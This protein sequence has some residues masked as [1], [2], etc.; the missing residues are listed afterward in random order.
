MSIKEPLKTILRKYCHVECYDPQLIREAI[1]TG[2][3]FPYDVELF[4]SQLREAI[5]KELISPE[6]YEK[7]T[8]EDFDSQEELQ[9]WL[10]EFW[11]E[12]F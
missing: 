11:S 2:R 6:E 5:D 10:E 12:L 8:E 1:K 7:L 9:I 3:G 4:K